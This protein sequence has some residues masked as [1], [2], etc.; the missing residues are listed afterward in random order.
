MPAKTKR[1]TPAMMGHG[2]PN[3]DLRMQISTMLRTLLLASMLAIP[4]FAQTPPAPTPPPP[5]AKPADVATPEAI[6]AAL[7]DVIS[8]PVGQ[9]RDWDRFRSLFAEGARLIPSGGPRPDG[10]LG[11]RVMTPE[12]YI[13]RGEK[14]L[15]ESGFT[16]SEIH[17]VV[18][19]FGP[20]THVFSTYEAR[21][22]SEKEPFL[23]G[24]NSIQLVHDGKR[25]YVLTIFWAP[26]SDTRKI[27]PKYLPASAKA[28]K[29]AK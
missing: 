14:M 15:V 28:K 10:T 13:T 11:Y 12:D 4:A 25:W 9:K 17:R 6:V 23:R 1:R 7:Y 27:P 18:E 20:V 8:G 3:R 2:S 26:E 29:A 24:V 19:N 22:N 16:E 21:H 5:E